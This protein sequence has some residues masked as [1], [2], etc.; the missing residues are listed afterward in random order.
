M[1]AIKTDSFHWPIPLEKYDR[2]SKVTK[3]ELELLQVLVRQQC[4]AEYR[5]AKW[6]KPLSRILLP[7]RDAADAVYGDREFIDT[8]VRAILR[9][10]VERKRT[11]WS[12]S[13]R[14]WLDLLGERASKFRKA[15]GWRPQW[16]TGLFAVGY[17]LQCLGEIRDYGPLWVTKLAHHVFGPSA[18]QKS[19]A[20]VLN[21]LEEWGYGKTRFPALIVCLHEVMLINRSPRLEDLTFDLLLKVFGEPGPESRR[22]GLYRIS[23]AAHQLGF[24]EKP[25]PHGYSLQRGGVS[26]HLRE[27]ID[28]RWLAFMDRWYA[29]ATVEEST[30]HLVF[31]TGLKAGRWVT[32]NFPDQ[33]SP[34]LWTRQ[35]AAQYVAAACRLTYGSWACE[36]RHKELHGKPLKASSIAGYLFAM[37]TVFRDAAEWEWIPR[38]FDPRLCLRPPSAIRQK[39]GPHP[40]PI[41]DAVWAKM[42]CAGLNLTKQDVGKHNPY[43]PALLRATAI[44]WLFAG[45]RS[46]EI[47][48][49]PVGAIS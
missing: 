19:Q 27:G 2:S 45:L 11:I 4:R 8:A 15:K 47:F 33:A 29:T 22:Y 32:K 30:R 23:F 25:L 18:V 13:H 38:R 42:V 35:T 28:P 7:L 37:R 48:R 40:K 36:V 31:Y 1:K 3:E 24:I 34:E 21:L 26:K 20:R 44:I 41:A 6:S 12:W 39:L 43:P 10:T 46:D 16:R 49:L 9:E 5:K 17:L 14:D